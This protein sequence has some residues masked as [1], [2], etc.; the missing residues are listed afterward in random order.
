MPKVK[1]TK[2]ENIDPAS[3]YFEEYLAGSTIIDICRKYDKS[4]NT[5]LKYLRQNDDFEQ[6]GS[7]YKVTGKNRKAGN[8][9]TEETERI[10]FNFSQ[11]LKSEIDS[12]CPGKNRTDK[13][14]KAIESYLQA[15]AAKRTKAKNKSSDSNDS[16]HVLL[17][18]KLVKKMDRSKGDRTS[19]VIAAIEIY[20][21]K[22]KK[23]TQ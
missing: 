7:G 8:I 3:V 6:P 11:D 13:I 16:F 21:D 20:V 23:L 1:I 18:A 5:V 2:D 22:F 12:Y 10:Y 17:P 4:R 14:C 9:R 15:P 19:K